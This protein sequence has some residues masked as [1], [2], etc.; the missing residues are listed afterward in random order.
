M[1]KE[2]KSEHRKEVRKAKMPATVKLQERVFVTERVLPSVILV[3][4]RNSRAGRRSLVQ[5]PVTGFSS[6][7]HE[8]M[9]RRISWP[10]CGNTWS[11]H[12]DG[13]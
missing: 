4:V 13:W 11:D 6:D 1:S 8:H 12:S 5:V 3:C 2:R 7:T 10:Q 9:R